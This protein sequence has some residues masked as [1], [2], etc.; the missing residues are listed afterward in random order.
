MIKKHKQEEKRDY[1][2]KIAFITPLLLVEK[3]E[4]Q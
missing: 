4:V 2:D 1:L 3:V